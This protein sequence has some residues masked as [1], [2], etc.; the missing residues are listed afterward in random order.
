[1]IIEQVKRASDIM[2]D[3][4]QDPTKTCDGISVG[5]GFEAQAGALGNPVVVLPVAMCP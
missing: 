4:T 3:G 5:L 1:M 2:V